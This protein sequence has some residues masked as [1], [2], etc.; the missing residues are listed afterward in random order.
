MIIEIR[1]PSLSPDMTEGALAIWHVK[2]GDRI[3]RGD[4]LCEIES[5]KATMEIEAPADGVME[6]ILIG[7]GAREIKVGSTLAT[8]LRE[9]ERAG[10]ARVDPDWPA[11]A[12]ILRQPFRE[13]L[14][15]AL[16]DAMR[17][18]PTVFL[19]GEEVAERQGA[20]KVSQGLFEEF[21]RKRVIDAPSTEYALAGLACGAAFAGLRP[22][23]EFMSFDY[24][25]QAID[26]IVNT[27]AKTHYISGARLPCPVVFRGPSGGGAQGGAMHSHD[28]A[29]WFAA[30]PGLKVVQPFCAADAKGLLR[31]AIRDP[32]PV[33]FLENEALYGRSSDVPAVDCAI[34]LGKA[35]IRREGQDVTLVSFGI[36][37]I[38]TL[39]A[40]EV[41]AEDGVS[42]EVIDLRCLRPLDIQTVISSVRRTNRC[43]T[44]EEGFPV[45]SIGAEI[46]ATLMREAF[47]HLDAPVLNCAGAD[48][49]MPYAASLEKAAAP[50]ARSVIEAARAICNR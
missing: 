8:F 17:E 41:L 29:A 42:A 12:A 14:R 46:S 2:Q 6:R 48:A 33:I 45:C 25:M 28:F 39:E 16:R 24:A 13:A 44:V 36:G 1:M 35:R 50:T 22:V 3:A 21:G 27:A 7:A 31:T 38:A 5:D 20:Y 9:E 4:V 49:P 32:N 10:F 18:D 11:G 23:V 34:P 37:M 47:D 19:I 15:D 40:A 43:V 26:H 30:V